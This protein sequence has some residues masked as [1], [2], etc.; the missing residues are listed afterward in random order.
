[1]KN[2]SGER[3][4]GQYCPIAAGLDVIGDRWVLL[5]CRELGM[6][7]QRFT[8]LRAALTGIAPNLLTERLRSLQAAGLVETVE[9]P[10]PAA[11][12]VYQ[13]TAQGRG[14]VPVLRAVARFG[15]HQLEPDPDERFTASR[16]A[17]SLMAPWWRAGNVAEDVTVRLDL[18]DSAADLVSR[19]RD[20]QVLPADDDRQ[21]DVVIRTD[22]PALVHARQTGER[23]VARVSGSAAKRKAALA[24]FALVPV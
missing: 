8:D 15:V 5:I 23:L 18:E 10:P 24:A 20:L 9:L 21:P 11:R 14:V 4:Y 17:Y 12:S 6:G 13:L 19:G 22:I 3:T 1:M 16:A 7:P 2:E